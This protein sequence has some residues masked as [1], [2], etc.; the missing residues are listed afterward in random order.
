[1]TNQ[2]LKGTN[3]IPNSLNITDITRSYPMIVTTT[4]VNNAPNPRVNTYQPGMNVRVFVPRSYGMFQAN[5][6][7]GTI[8][9]VTGNVF[10]LDL[11]S[12]QFDVFV[13]PP[14]SA[15]TPA[16]ISPAGSKNLEYNNT[17][18]S[19]APFRNLNN[20]GN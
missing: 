8:L 10:I 19:A 6:L 12:T 14:S 18:A 3:T 9:D 5:G 13:I 16:S 11:D 7:V 20:I 17:N 2:Y 1:L 4:L 15:E